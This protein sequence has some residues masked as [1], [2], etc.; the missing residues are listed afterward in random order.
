M[1]T[2]LLAVALAV[3]VAAPAGARSDADYGFQIDLIAAGRAFEDGSLIQYA[4]PRKTTV[5]AGGRTRTVRV[6]GFTVG[7]PERAGS[8]LKNLRGRYPRTTD[9]MVDRPLTPA[10]RRYAESVLVY[11]DG[12]VLA[13]H[14]THPL[15]AA[16]TT[17]SAVRDMLRSSAR[18]YVPAGLTGDPERMFGVNTFGSGIRTVSEASAI[19][20]VRS[21]PE[22]FA[23]VAW[24]AVRDELESGEVCAVALSGVAPSEATLRDRSYPASVHATYAYSRRWYSGWMSYVPRWYKAF[25][26]SEKI[27]DL[28]ETARGRRRL[29]P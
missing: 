25:L 24:S 26:R 3:V 20:T 18:G 13:V 2:L 29:L 14:P 15:C 21:D 22:T 19:N 9:A 4:L 11:V 17:R 16:G 12:D 1:R 7:G 10:E 23:A 27:R 5:R 8:V 28:L 6:A